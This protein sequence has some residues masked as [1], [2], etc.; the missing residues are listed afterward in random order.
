LRRYIKE[1]GA[2]ANKVLVLFR[3]ALLIYPAGVYTRPLFGST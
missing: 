1:L 3:N 2:V